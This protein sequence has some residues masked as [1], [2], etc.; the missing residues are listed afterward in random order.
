[1]QWPA[2]TTHARV[3]SSTK[4]LGSARP[5]DRLNLAK[6]CDFVDESIHPGDRAMSIMGDGKEPVPRVP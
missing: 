3:I 2:L 1:M 4:S 6:A 5:A